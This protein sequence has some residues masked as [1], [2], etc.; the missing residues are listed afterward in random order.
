LRPDQVADG[1]LRA[2]M[3][4][5]MENSLRSFL[6]ELVVYAMLVVGYFFLVLNF[7]GPWLYRLYSEER[8]TYAF[9]ALA[10]IIGQG[11]V[12]EALTRFLLALIRPRM[13]EE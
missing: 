9:V 11:F 3:K 13:E 12:L 5:E 8:R 7:L 2:A 10:L 1:L 6:V 4:K